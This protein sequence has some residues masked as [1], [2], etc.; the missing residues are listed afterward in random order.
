MHGCNQ[1]NLR[2][3]CRGFGGVSGKFLVQVYDQS[4]EVVCESV[5]SI[6]QAVQFFV[7]CPKEYRVRARS[8]QSAGSINPQ[9]QNA[10]IKVLPGR[11]KTREFIFYPEIRPFCRR[12]VDMNFNV[13][14]YHYPDLPIHEGVLIYGPVFS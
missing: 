10:W 12:Y 7:N 8:L 5:T 3:I 2:I 4:G 6:N 14:D 1:E 13:M 9:G 11:T